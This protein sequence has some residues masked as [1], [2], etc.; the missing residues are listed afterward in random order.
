[1]S[2]GAVFLIGFLVFH[3]IVFCFRKKL[4]YVRDNIENEGERERM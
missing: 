2:S 4:A 3:K 1:M